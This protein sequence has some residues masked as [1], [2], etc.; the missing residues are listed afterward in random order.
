L[1]CACVFFD[2]VETQRAGRA[3]AA[4]IQRRDETGIGL[5]FLQL[6]AEAG[7]IHDYSFNFR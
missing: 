4:L 3:T 6:F 2:P 1:A 5:H 7:R